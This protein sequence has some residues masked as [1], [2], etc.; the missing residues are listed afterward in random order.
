MIYGTSINKIKI[1][2]SE[3]KYQAL[4]LRGSSRSQNWFKSINSTAKIIE[5]RSTFYLYLTF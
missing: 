1:I 4:E 3:W 2:I 5:A